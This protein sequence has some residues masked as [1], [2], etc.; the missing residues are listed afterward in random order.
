MA[1]PIVQDSSAVLPSRLSKEDR[2]V[3]RPVRCRPVAL[4]RLRAHQVIRERGEQ[5]TVTEKCSLWTPV[6]PIGRL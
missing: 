1:A 6:F 5:R 2:W 4:P 3:I